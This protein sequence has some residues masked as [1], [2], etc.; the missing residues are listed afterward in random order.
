VS[1]CMPL[2]LGMCDHGAIWQS[3][4]EWKAYISYLEIENWDFNIL[5]DIWLWVTSIISFLYGKT[6]RDKHFCIDSLLNTFDLTRLLRFVHNISMVS[7]FLI[8]Y[9][10]M[11][12]RLDKMLV[13]MIIYRPTLCWFCL[14][15]C[16]GYNSLSWATFG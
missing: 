12:L 11:Y 4:N 15:L 8:S 14:I 6:I 10:S 7:H 5:S 13:L 2:K 1:A 9:D 16:L 3:T